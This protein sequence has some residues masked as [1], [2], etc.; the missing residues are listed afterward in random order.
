MDQ[1]AN[2]PVSGK[3]LKLLATSLFIDK[4]KKMGVWRK[5]LITSYDA[6]IDLFSGYTDDSE[7]MPFTKPKIYV[8][9]DAEN[10]FVF[11]TRLIS[12]LKLR[13]LADNKIY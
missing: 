11:C 5:V 3:Q 6:A 2:E 13:D 10:P 1:K 12:A 7:K 8:L 9:F 4:Q